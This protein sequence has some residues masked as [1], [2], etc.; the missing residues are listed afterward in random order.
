MGRAYGPEDV[1]RGA[2]LLRE[3]KGDPFLACDMITGFPGEGEGE[4]EKTLALC[5]KIG[6]AWIHAFPY[7][8]RPGTV[9][10]SFKERVSE[11]DSARRADTLLDLARRGRREYVRRW[12]G[13]ETEVIIEGENE[14]KPG[15]IQ[16]VS[17]N[18]LRLLVH[19]P[20]GRA[21]PSAGTALKCRIRELSPEEGGGEGLFDAAGIV[22]E[23][24]PLS[25]DFSI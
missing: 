9:A 5:G 4:F 3:I 8:P 23:R 19:I 18:Y 25:G 16:G 11:R 6:F 17:D 1:E 24:V 21:R 13:K 10:W 7:S 14:K 15:F 22:E 12:I 2:E 20:R